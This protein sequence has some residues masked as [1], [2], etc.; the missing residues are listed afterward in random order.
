MEYALSMPSSPK[1][2]YCP[3]LK[4]N[5]S[6]S[7]SNFIIIRSS[8]MSMRSTS[9]ALGKAAH[10]RY[11]RDSTSLFLALLVMKTSCRHGTVQASI[12][13]TLAR[14]ISKPGTLD[15]ASGSSLAWSSTASCPKIEVTD[16]TL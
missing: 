11:R 16:I 8:L 5:G 12:F 7:G 10:C 9:V 2:Q 3:G 14:R 13:V 1:V 4:R 6:V 15:A